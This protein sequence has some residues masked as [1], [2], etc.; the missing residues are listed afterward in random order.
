MKKTTRYYC[1]FN[2]F[3]TRKPEVTIDRDGIETGA[4]CKE[5]V[6]SCQTTS[7][8][9]VYFRTIA[10]ARTFIEKLIDKRF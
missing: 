10:E 6:P 1:G 4:F 7:Y 3:D 9:G 5:V 2:I 8:Y